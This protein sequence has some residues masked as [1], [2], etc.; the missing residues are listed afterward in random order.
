MEQHELVKVGLI[1]ARV[2][3]AGTY[4]EALEWIRTTNPAGTEN[5]WGKNAE[6]AFAPVACADDKTRTHFMFI[7]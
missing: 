6:G 2:C 7:C 1:D 5:N 3:S 4:D